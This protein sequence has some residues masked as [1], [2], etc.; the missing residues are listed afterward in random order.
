MGML[1]CWT[2]SI[3]LRYGTALF[4]FQEIT[5]ISSSPPLDETDSDALWLFE[6]VQVS[7]LR[8]RTASPFPVI[9]MRVFNLPAPSLLPQHQLL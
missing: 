3:Y 1:S 8:I 4:T 2:D 9:P 6:T 7:R 5:A